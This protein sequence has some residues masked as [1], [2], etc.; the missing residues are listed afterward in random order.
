ME[1]G[2]SNGRR[3]RFGAFEA[4]LQAGELR[5]S[6]IRVR[7]QDQPFR[8]LALLLERS[9]EVVSREKLRTEIW[10]DDTFVD[11]DHSLNT[12]INKIREALGDSASHPRFVETIPRRGY[13]F[14]FPLPQTAGKGEAPPRGES[15]G[16]ASGLQ[17]GAV[18]T[19]E[20][21]KRLRFQRVGLLAL[22]AV[23]AAMI[24]IQWRGSREGARPVARFRVPI[25]TFNFKGFPTRKHVA[26]T[27]DGRHL[28]YTVFQGE[29]TSLYVRALDQLDATAID[30]TERAVAPFLSPNGEWVGFWAEGELRKV[31]IGGGPSIKLCDLRRL[32]YGVSWGPN[33]KVVFGEQNGGLQQVSADGGDP[34]KLTT[35]DTEKGEASHRLPAWLPGGEALLFTVRKRTVGSWDDSQIMVQSLRTGERKVLIENG[36]DARYAPSGHLVFAR[37]GTLMAAPF[38]L[39]RLKVT[40]SPV[41]IIEGVLQ[42]ANLQGSNLDTGATQ[43][44]FSKSG[45]LVYLPGGIAPDLEHSLVWVDGEGRVEPL[46]TPN[47]PYS[48]PSLSPDGRQIALVATLASGSL[49]VWV[50]D[51]SRNTMTRLTVEGDNLF[52]SW[53]PD[54]KRVTFATITRGGVRNLFWRPADL[55]APAE[56][57]TT[58]ADWQMAPTWSPDGEHLAIVVYKPGGSQTNRDIEVVS[59]E[60]DR[61]AQPFV[62][63]PFRETHPTFSPNGRWLAYASNQSGRAEVYV[64]AYPG[65][66]GVHQISTEEAWAPAWS[67]NGRELFYRTRTMMMAVDVRTEPT[68]V[69]GK[70]RVLFDNRPY[71]FR[72]PGRN[73]D[74][75]PDGQRFLMVQRG[76]QPRVE[77]THA[78]V[79]MNWFEEL[80]RL[81]RPDE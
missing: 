7:L 53:T 33:N 51:I 35:L 40:G 57:L 22:L 46:A 54:G 8:V 52:P 56:R 10:P 15:P 9:G 32:P 74:V 73:Y 34:E 68:F 64:Q 14:V 81:A 78:V 75:A 65:P 23:A 26:V 44:N 71:V 47:G 58:S 48:T 29:S 19:I 67:P 30:G 55:S 76:K 1:T 59:I 6:G 25:D 45:L 11:F 3:V 38:D 36:A 2:S 77:I 49:D 80:K 18:A 79:V 41:G 31:P 21:V 24:V 62:E 16:E 20:P 60:G 17:S 43:F 69:A 63:G 39:G 27:P 66:G 12:A 50:Y 70:P 42:A 61:K 13:R 28:V 72:N 4:D 37:L 5:K